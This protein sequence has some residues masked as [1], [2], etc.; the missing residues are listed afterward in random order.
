MAFLTLLEAFLGFKKN[1]QNFWEH[2]LGA[3]RVFSNILDTLNLVPN[4]TNFFQK[5][6]EMTLPTFPKAFSR[7]LKVFKIL[8]TP[9][10]CQ[11][12]V[13]Q[14][15]GDI[16]VGYNFYYL[17]QLFLEMTLPTLP[18]AFSRLTL[19]IGVQLLFVNGYLVNKRIISNQKWNSLTFPQCENNQVGQHNG[20]SRP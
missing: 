2:P 16:E 6:S 8:E 1:A 10:P 20:S 12:V 19:T 14:H 18:R 15:Y 5:P 13:F 17:S 7:L 4:S 9:S 3:K 11:V